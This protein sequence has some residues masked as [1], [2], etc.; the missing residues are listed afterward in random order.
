MCSPLGLKGSG[1]ALSC[2]SCPCHL[3]FSVRAFLGNE[4][5]RL[6]RAGR[7]VPMPEHKAHSGEAQFVLAALG[8]V[9]GSRREAST[10]VICPRQSFSRCLE[11]VQ[12]DVV[13]GRGLDRQA[14][15]Q[16]A[17]HLGEAGQLEAAEQSAGIVDGAVVGAEDMASPDGVVVLVDLLMAVGAPAGAAENQRDAVV[18]LG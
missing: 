7:Q 11:A 9:S 5:E 1:R 17:V 2:L 15:E 4:P 18:D 14:E 13:V 16:L 3:A 6:L 10:A 12:V 8:T